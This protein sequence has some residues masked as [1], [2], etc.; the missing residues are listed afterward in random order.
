MKHLLIYCNSLQPSGGIERVV[1]TLSN[2]FCS[3]MQVSII[4]KDEALSFYDLNE[5]V[6][7]R[8]LNVLGQFNMKNRFIRF[9]QVILS[10]YRSIRK[11]SKIDFQKFDFIYTVHPSNALELYIA[12]G[13]HFNRVICTEHG[14]NNAYNF[15]YRKIKTWLYPKAE[16]YVVP[17]TKDLE[18][19]KIKGITNTIHI[20]H[21]VPKMDFIQ[22]KLNKRIALNV[23]RFNEAKQQGILVDVWSKIVNEGKVKNWKLKIVGSGELQSFLENK[24]KKLQ[25]EDHIELNKPVKDIEKYYSEASIFLLTSKSEGFGM[26]LI[27]A[28]HFGV[29]CISFNCPSGPKDI[30]QN[31]KNGYLVKQNDITEFYNKLLTYINSKELQ[32]QLSAGAKQSIKFWNDQNILKKWNDIIKF[33]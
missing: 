3:K 22:S 30:I 2:I 1:S 15:V 32:I 4:V 33:Q 28:L 7:M 11:L 8:S 27:E 10:N 6:N 31:G 13:R 5:G 12:Q 9:A 21:F 26:V 19:Y 25:L 17:T 20:P 18:Y 16:A 23:G 24:I 29:P 14:G